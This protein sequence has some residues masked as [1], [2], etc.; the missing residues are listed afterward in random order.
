M[1]VDVGLYPPAAFEANEV[2]NENNRFVLSRENLMQVPSVYTEVMYLL[3]GDDLHY[4]PRKQDYTQGLLPFLST[5]KKLLTFS[6][7]CQY[8]VRVVFKAT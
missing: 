6:R 5:M 8:A 2:L 3:V 1:E 4:S 7:N